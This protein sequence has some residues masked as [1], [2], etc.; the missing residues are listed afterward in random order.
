[1]TIRRAAAELL[2]RGTQRQD[3]ALNLETLPRAAE[4]ARQLWSAGNIADPDD[5]GVPDQRWLESAIGHWAGKLALFW[6]HRLELVWRAGINDWKGLN[7]ETREAFELM[8]V[9]DG[10]RNALARSVIASQLQ[11]LHAADQDWTTDR[12][13][14]L[15]NWDRDAPVAG[16]VWDG[17]LTWGRIPQALMAPLMVY[18][19]QGLERRGAGPRLRDRLLEHLVSIALYGSFVRLGADGWF[20]RAIATMDDDDRSSFAASMGR[21]LKAGPPE[22]GEAAFAEWLVTYWEQR[23]SGVP[24]SL[25]PGETFEMVDWLL[26]AG[27]S[28]PTAVELLAR[29]VIKPSESHRMFFTELAES[30]YL[31][32]FPGSSAKLVYTVTTSLNG[33]IDDVDV[34]ERLVRDLSQRSSEDPTIAACLQG[35]REA[36]VR[37]GRTQAMGW[38]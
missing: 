30:G 15:F 32:R 25:S 14:S 36:L 16:Q 5:H 34:L 1:M 27:A 17:F 4:L 23:L 2:E 8:I 11:F 20:T 24:A 28:F 35:V 3:V 13:L 12:L 6:V 21:H 22:L 26:H 37:L 9:G 10:L 38:T 7:P 33:L 29:A 31:E 19:Q 18:Y